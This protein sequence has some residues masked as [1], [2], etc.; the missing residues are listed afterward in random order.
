MALSPEPQRFAGPRPAKGAGT[1]SRVGA[2][3]VEMTD[4][5]RMAGAVA[6]DFNNLLVVIQ[7]YTDMIAATLPDEDP[8]QHDAEEIRQAIQQ[9]G[10]LTRQLMTFGRQSP[11]NLQAVDIDTLVHGM[12][13]ML[14]WLA[15]GPIE[16]DM[17][18]GASGATVFADPAQL[19]QVLLNLV[20]NARD[21]MP[22]GGR[23]SI[24]TDVV[25]RVDCP[26]TTT[27]NA[28]GRFVTLTVD[29]TGTGMDEETQ[30]HVF[31]PYFT[32]KERDSGTG[33]GLAAVHQIIAR[34]GGWVQI[35]SRPGAGTRMT[36]YLPIG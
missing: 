3:D 31:D 4:F 10:R 19:E 18:A 9:A 1:S 33:L 13:P 24:S 7:G 28:P 32:T 29:D 8:R 16:L 20:L 27:A 11:L 23:I 22:D 6:H 2:D 15:G 17:S 14:R 36:V 5:G 26:E 12:R 30:R 25:D 21:A 34:T 35:L